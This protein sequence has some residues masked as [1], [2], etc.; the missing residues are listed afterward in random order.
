[1]NTVDTICKNCQYT[2]GGP[3]GTID[4][5][6]E[7]YCHRKALTIVPVDN[8]CDCFVAITHKQDIITS[9]DELCEIYKDVLEE[10]AK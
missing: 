9:C 6:K 5:A 4:R 1:M 7:R 10:L 2:L 3:I 8:C